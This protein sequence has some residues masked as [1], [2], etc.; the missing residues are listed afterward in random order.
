MLIPYF[1]HRFKPLQ[2][3][4]V[5]GRDATAEPKCK[6]SHAVWYA[7]K[8]DELSAL[9][10]R[11]GNPAMRLNFP[12]AL[13]A[14]TLRLAGKSAGRMAGHVARASLTRVRRVVLLTVS[15]IRNGSVSGSACRVRAR[16]H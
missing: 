14:G 7:W 1:N 15:D 12:T 4:Q 2:P 3:L 13:L 16:E 11:G 10:W 5:F 9:L 6:P 8:D